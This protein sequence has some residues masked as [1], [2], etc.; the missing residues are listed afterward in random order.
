M[1]AAFEPALRAAAALEEHRSLHEFG[2]AM[3]ARPAPDQRYGK[4]DFSRQARC[5]SVWDV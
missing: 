4:M 3:Q 5:K 1:D 2:R